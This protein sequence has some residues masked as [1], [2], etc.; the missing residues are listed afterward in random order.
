MKKSIVVLCAML[1][2]LCG[3]GIVGS[4][5][6]L[7]R[8][9]SAQLPNL[10]PFQPTG[11]SDKI[12]VSTTTGNNTDSSVINDT[13]IIYIDWA[14][15]NDG[16]TDAGQFY[17]GLYV[18]DVLIVQGDHSSGLSANY[19]SSV[20]DYSI[21]TLSPGT[22]TISVSADNTGLVT[23]SNEADNTYTK[24][25]HVN[26]SGNS[27]R[28]TISG[29]VSDGDGTPL[30]AMVL[31]NGQHMFTSNPIG[32]Y[33]LEVPLNA[34][35]EIT[36]YA[37]C[38][39][40][41]PFKAV[42]TP[43]EA[44][45]LDIELHSDPYEKQPLVTI[46]RLQ[47]SS[48]NP[49]WFDISGT[50]QNEMGTPLIAM[51]LAN[52]QHMFTSDPVGEY[53]LTVPLDSNGM[54][55]LYGFC[56]GK[57]PYKEII[58]AI[59]DD[60]T[61]T[62]QNSLLNGHYAFVLRGFDPDGNAV[63]IGGSFTTDGSGNIGGGIMDINNA[64]SYPKT[65]LTINPAPASFYS[66]STDNRGMLTLNT[67][68]GTQTF[69]FA[70]DSITSGVASS[71]HIISRQYT[72]GTNGSAIS[73][74]IK[75]QDM[76]AIALPAVNGDWVF[77][78]EG[79]NA[80][81]GGLSVSVGRFTVKNGVISNG[82]MDFQTQGQS[83]L[84]LVLTGSFGSVDTTN[85]RVSLSTTTSG[86]TVHNAVYIVSANES[87][88]MSIDSPS[89]YKPIATGVALLQ[90]ATFC[91]SAGNC[92]FTDNALNG[93]V[94]MY[95]Q[96][97]NRGTSE[98]ASE[99]HDMVGV[100][101]FTPTSNSFTF[102]YDRTGRTSVSSRNGTYS[103]SSNGRAELHPEAGEFFLYLVD[104]NRAL[105]LEHK[106]F[107]V[108]SYFRAGIAEPQVGPIAVGS[109]SWALGSV[110]PVVSGMTVF[111]GIQTIVATSGTTGNITNAV[112]DINS[113]A[114]G[115]QEN[116]STNDDTFTID[117]SGRVT[118]GNDSKVGYWINANK[119]VMIATP[120]SGTEPILI[121]SDAQ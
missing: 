1:W 49:E 58:D 112:S 68:D 72:S 35:D 96:G 110:S 40:R 109:G 88:I 118:F 106:S 36:L 87:F 97:N 42:L 54:I 23:E 38:S 14:V 75:K 113:L 69:D 66:V 47:E 4:D 34:Y 93:N 62:L 20:I 100:A 22:H 7:L 105:L 29:F 76:S 16:T 53:S 99:P 114:G 89:T 80:T 103:V 55:T 5:S 15:L 65:S 18:D 120:A 41:R 57:M 79:D 28:V 10:T 17:S 102:F 117:S 115:L 77:L 44:S 73:G 116:V 92:N 86:G 25:I 31:A 121:V 94:V 60:G 111:S 63:A 101:T 3:G 8:E 56:S 37:F 30:V 21:G 52:G 51:I 48:S 95:T 98:R 71:G 104:T 91:P 6:F 32:E 11:W 61:G 27:T 85:G 108:D 19:Y 81:Y 26:A 43:Q 64:G 2:L 13:D 59:D 50:I 107:T 33:S 90:S 39:G 67:S 74:I 46:D 83:H 24:T 78:N 84:N 70:L 82:I 12:V 119:M 9:A 45:Y